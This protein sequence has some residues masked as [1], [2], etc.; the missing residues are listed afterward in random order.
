MP[1]LL[2]INLP[3]AYKNPC[4]ISLLDHD[5]DQA[6][7][8]LWGGELAVGDDQKGLRCSAWPWS[9]GVT[10]TAASRRVS[11]P[12]SDGPAQTAACRAG[13]VASDSGDAVINSTLGRLLCDC[14]ETLE[15]DKRRPWL[16]ASP[17][18]KGSERS[19]RPHATP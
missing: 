7:A 11:S 12:T 14:E 6:A 18:K 1:P 4:F 2:Q 17:R 15:P 13:S 5:F 10:W 8:L 9:S 19:E 3:I 16:L